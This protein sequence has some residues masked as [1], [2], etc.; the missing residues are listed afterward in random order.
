LTSMRDTPEGIRSVVLDSVFPPQVNG[1]SESPYIG[2]WV[3]NQI[4]EN[5]EADPGCTADTKA[6]IE[7]G[8]LRVA[9]EPIDGFDPKAYMAFVGEQIANPQLLVAISVFASGTD[10]EVRALLVDAADDE[11]D[12]P[13]YRRAPAI[14]LPLHHGGIWNGL[15]RGLCGGSPVP[16]PTGEPGP[17]KIGLR[18]GCHDYQRA[19]TTVSR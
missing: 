15:Q 19:R 9:A 16:R 13:P 18:E 8:L 1:L 12:L 10:D 3:I 5:C 14:H 6:L 17:L 2:Y 11:E 7:E 4:E